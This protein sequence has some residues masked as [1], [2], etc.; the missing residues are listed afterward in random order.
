MD[1]ASVA[2]RVRGLREARGW[3]QRALDRASGLSHGYVSKLEAGQIPNFSVSQLRKI[4]NALGV[5]VEDMVGGIYESSGE[6]GEKSGAS[7]GGRRGAM[8]GEI[9][10]ITANVLAIGDLDE[11]ALVHLREIVIA[12]KESAERR[13]KEA[14]RAE[15][16]QRKDAGRAGQADKEV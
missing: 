9:E 1:A 10:E 5:T 7:G 16:R 3:S 12:M 8:R 15:R 4:A 13:R 2:E 14:K 6:S 11:G